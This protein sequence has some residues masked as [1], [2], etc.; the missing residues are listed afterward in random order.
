MTTTS[1]PFETSAA[2]LLA[3]RV[4]RGLSLTV[5]LTLILAAA[6]LSWSIMGSI[7]RIVDAPAMLRPV[8]EIIRVQTPTGGSIIQINVREGQEVHEGDVLIRL[9]REDLESSL[10]QA[11]V[12]KDV[13]STRRSTVEA[14]MKRVDARG[15][16]NQEIHKQRIRSA[17]IALQER[18]LDH[19]KRLVAVKATVDSCTADM[20]QKRQYCDQMRVQADKGAATKTEVSQAATDVKLAEAAYMK[21]TA[22]AE[23]REDAVKLAEQELQLAR[24]NAALASVE[25]EQAR[26]ENQ[27]QMTDL[28]GEI[29]RLDKEIAHIN[30]QLSKCTIRATAS[31]TILELRVKHVGELAS[32]GDVLGAIVPIS[33]EL[34]VEARILDRDIAFIHTG[35]EAKV[36]LAALPYGQYGQ[37]NAS[38][39]TVAKDV[40]MSSNGTTAFVVRCR[41]ARQTILAQGHELRL[42][43]G[44]TGQ[45][46]I[47]THR[48][49]PLSLLTSQLKNW[50][51]AL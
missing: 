25:W 34:E 5:Y 36:R 17:E 33:A 8:G 19:K 31:G 29:D 47:T 43:P 28:Q 32:A 51:E 46:S 14:E 10:A 40:V 45:V 18:Q 50:R 20:E 1:M 37:I 23:T 35:Q 21:A 6:G 39:A 3:R 4:P 12:K 27:R 15:K 48:Q 22:E 7:D 2:S 26:V 41:L 16:L 30:D 42:S 38:V 9:K 11:Q 13:L 49:S 44:M 24:D